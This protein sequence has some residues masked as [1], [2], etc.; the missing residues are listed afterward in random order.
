MNRKT[1]RQKERTICD[2]MQIRKCREAD[3]APAG[4]FYDSVVLW[5]DNHINYPKW[6]YKIYPSEI[7]V[8]EMTAAGNQY[9]CVDGEKIIGAF[10]LNADP[11]GNYQKGD[12][13]RKLPDGAY[14]VLHALAIAPELQGHG[15]GEEVVRFCT[16][17]AKTDGYKA[18]RLDIVPGNL[19]AKR[20]Y[21]KNGFRYVGD[22]DLERGLAHI[23]IFSL[24]E[25]DW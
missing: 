12:W 7:S 6:M 3:V 2:T 22:V 25:L 18:L 9:L 21:E 16:E 19:P 4:A 15:L 14:M 23:P 13:S 1:F 10:A 17:K 8:R 11:Q 24:Y 20:L 5:L